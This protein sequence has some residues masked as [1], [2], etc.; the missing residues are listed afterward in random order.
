[1]ARRDYSDDEDFYSQ[2]LEKKGLVSVWLGMKD[3]SAERDIDT[4]QDL[5]GVGYYR[6]SDQESNSFNY[7]FTDIPLLLADL[8][9]SS[10]YAEEVIKAAKAKGIEKARRIIVQYDFAYDP[11][12]VTRTIEDDPIFI[13]VFPYSEAL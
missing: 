3:R 4:L 11:A 13:G 9:Y 6:L 12:V 1:M 10:S 7:E 2:G 5:C 8:S